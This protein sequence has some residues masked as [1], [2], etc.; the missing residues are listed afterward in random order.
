MSKLNV[1]ALIGNLGAAPVIGESKSGVVY[2]QFSIAINQRWKDRGGESRE[3]TDWI[4]VVAFNG[5]AKTLGRLDKGDQVAVHGRL[6]SQTYMDRRSGEKRTVVEVVALSV[7]FLRLKNRPA[8]TDGDTE[9]DLESPGA[10][11]A[12]VDDIPF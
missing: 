1:A 2:A 10:D 7:D 5:L 6:Q 9:L 11:Y 3:R 8:D 4:R 12:D